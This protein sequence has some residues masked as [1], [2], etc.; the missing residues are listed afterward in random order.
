MV[1]PIP[2][3]LR[4][5]SKL[6][7]WPDTG[8]VRVRASLRSVL[9]LLPVQ[10]STVGCLTPPAIRVLVAWE[11]LVGMRPAPETPS[12]EA[13]CRNW[14]RSP[15]STATL[16]VARICVVWAPPT[17]ALPTTEGLPSQCCGSIPNF[18]RLLEPEP[19]LDEAAN[20]EKLDSSFWKVAAGSL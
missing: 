14:S 8:T 1:S 15:S 17:V 19:P 11:M 5:P 13:L 3:E 4:P 12:D 18:D 16:T 7:A 6:D 2:L 9:S 10:T 20:W